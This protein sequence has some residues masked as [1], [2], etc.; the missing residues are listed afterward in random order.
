[1]A[2]IAIGRRDFRLRR[3]G[4]S[5]LIYLRPYAREIRALVSPVVGLVRDFVAFKG[6]FLAA[7]IAFFA[8]LSLFP[9]TIALVT[10]LHLTLGDSGFDELLHEAINRQ[11]PVLSQTETGSSLL[12]EFI[13]HTETN[14]AL[15]SSVS[16]LVLFISALGI[17]ATIRE[18]I[19]IAWGIERRRGFFLQRLVDAA[20]LIVT[21][22]LLLVSIVVSAVFSFLEEISHVVAFDTEALRHSFVHVAGLTVPWG[23][24]C[25]VLTLTYW[26]L[27]NAKISIKQILPVSLLATLMFELVKFAFVTYLHHDADRLFSIY[28]SFLALMMFFVFIFAEAIVLLAGAMICAK[29]IR[30]LKTSNQRMLIAEP[31]TRIERS[32]NRVRLFFAVQE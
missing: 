17:F 5:I 20:L 22:L 25:L 24:T 28:G 3:R 1:M 4:Y 30:Y 2:Q 29:W 21:S 14:S 19:N 32:A 8:F 7:A 27:P 15:T 13:T 16:G 11:I 18:S 26:W 9:L 10:L 12:E 31:T 6:H 23:I